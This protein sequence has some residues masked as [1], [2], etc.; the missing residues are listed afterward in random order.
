MQVQYGSVTVIRPRWGDLT[1]EVHIHGAMPKWLMDQALDE[2]KRQIGTYEETPLERFC[3][4]HELRINIHATPDN[5]IA[6]ASI[7]AS[8]REPGDRWGLNP[9]SAE[10]RTPAE[11]RRKL[12]EKI[13]GKTLV[14][15]SMLPIARDV[16]VPD[17][18]Q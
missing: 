14:I 2:A 12:S 16:P 3:R 1:L 6:R 7:E 18:E 11:A 10:G 17:L 9:C 4:E 5:D 15:G 13:S 8:Y